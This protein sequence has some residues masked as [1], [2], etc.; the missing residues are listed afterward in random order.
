MNREPLFKKDAEKYMREAK[1]GMS[2]EESA[3]KTVYD[4]RCKAVYLSRYDYNAFIQHIIDNKELFK[5]HLDREGKE[6]IRRLVNESR[7]KNRCLTSDEAYIIDDTL[8]GYISADDSEVVID[9]IIRQDKH[10]PKGYAFEKIL[11]DKFDATYSSFWDWINSDSFKKEAYQRKDLYG[12]M[13]ELIE[14]QKR[15]NIYIGKRKHYEPEDEIYLEEV[16]RMME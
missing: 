7:A 15:E 8:G 4:A 9:G 11:R 10:N 6:C 5:Y 2:D 3:M 13:C 14:H 16:K 1:N 12:L